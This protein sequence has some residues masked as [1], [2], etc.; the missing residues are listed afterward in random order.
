MSS[1]TLYSV[2][3]VKVAHRPQRPGEG[4]KKAS[5]G[6]K[7]NTRLGAVE[8]YQVALHRGE[9]CEN[10]S[11]GTKPALLRL[12]LGEGVGYHLRRAEGYRKAAEGNPARKILHALKRRCSLPRTTS[13]GARGAPGAF[14]SGLPRMERR[15]K[16]TNGARAKLRWTRPMRVHRAPKATSRKR[17]RPC[18][19]YGSRSFLGVEL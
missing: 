9:G 2:I 8:G 5:E 1:F 7:P 12:G 16:A 3:V 11:R 17:R 14:A 6:T 4:P 13:H 19:P 18:S 15:E 10:A